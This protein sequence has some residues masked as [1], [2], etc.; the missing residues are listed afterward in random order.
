MSKVIYTTGITGFIGQHFLKKIIDEYDVVINFGRDNTIGVYRN[1]LIP[2]SKKFNTSELSSL[3]SEV[4]F[5]FATHYN[6]KPKNQI[7]EKLIKESNFNF[8]FN[9][10][11][12]LKK[13]GLKKLICTSS[14]MQL[15]DHE[16]Q[17]SYS[18]TKNKF[19][20]WANKEFQMIEVFLFDTFGPNDNRNK[21]VDVFIKNLIK[22]TDIQIP[23]SRIDI[24]LTHVEEIV[25]CLHNS[26]KYPSGKYMIKSNNQLT[27]EELAKKII[28]LNNE[29]VNIVQGPYIQN[30]LQ[31]IQYFP[32]NIY[33]KTL[34]IDFNSQL[35]QRNN[36][37]RKT[38]TI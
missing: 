5:H 28:K 21:V 2:E 27:I 32:Q 35:N 34:K 37:I 9:L 22:K 26:H 33:K 15:L 7:E 6:P 11:N 24:N 1:S 31:N 18:K 25:N 10:C 8:P 12:E 17:N 13:N 36:E 3:R 23:K 14:Y 4:L 38:E 30:F 29:T 19:I 20:V 16:Y